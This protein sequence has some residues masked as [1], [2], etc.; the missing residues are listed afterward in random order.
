MATQIQRHIIDDETRT[1]QSAAAQI[2][3]LE[4]C[5]AGAEQQVETQE[6]RIRAS[7]LAGRNTAI[8]E[9]DLQKMQ[10]LLAI[11]REGRERVVRQLDAPSLTR[12]DA[13][14]RPAAPSA[15]G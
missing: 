4:R 5:I 14:V 10:L 7:A 11:L 1:S 6:A 2:E 15:S 8:D 9:F 3:R 12:V 13:V